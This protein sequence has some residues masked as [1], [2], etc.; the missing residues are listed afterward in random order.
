MLAHEFFGVLMAI[1]AGAVIV[2]AFSP[3]SQAGAVIGQSSA[4]FANVISAMK[5]S[6]GAQAQ[7]A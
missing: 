6:Q 5:G 2:S 7:A 3:G 4:G 1:V